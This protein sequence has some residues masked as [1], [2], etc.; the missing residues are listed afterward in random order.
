MKHYKKL[1]FVDATDTTRGPMAKIIM[2]KKFLLAP[3]TIESR[4]LVV[5]FPE[6]L[7]QK[8]EAVLISNGYEAD[9]HSAAALTQ[10]DIGDGEGVLLLTMENAQKEKIL[11]QFSN[12]RHLHT[13]TEF[14]GARG[15]VIPL[16]GAPLIEYG[17]YYEVLDTLLDGLVIKFNEEEIIG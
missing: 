6:P 2:K 4:G 13:L 9:G 1:I 17:Q 5:L 16:Y 10:E 15:E 3:L 14:V 12:L 11:E 7:N 8:A